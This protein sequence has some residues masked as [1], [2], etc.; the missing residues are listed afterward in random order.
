[1]TTY[2]DG[3][4]VQLR[5]SLRVFRSGDDE[6]RIPAGTRGTVLRGD[7]LGGRMIKVVLDG[8]DYLTRLIE[9]ANIEPVQGTEKGATE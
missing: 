8:E 5:T 6:T 3:D 1:M 4:R 2:A 7:L 9:S